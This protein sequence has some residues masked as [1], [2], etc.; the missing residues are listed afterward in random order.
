MNEQIILHSLPE[1][2]TDW[3]RIKQLT[4]KQIEAAC[5]SDDDVILPTSNDLLNGKIIY[6]SGEAFYI[7][8]AEKKIDAWLEEH[9]LSGNEVAAALLK[10]FVEAQ[11]GRKLGG[12]N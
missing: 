6:P 12:N 8:P 4:D 5:A 9:H 2:Q 11:I 1:S 10:Q 3:A 7:I